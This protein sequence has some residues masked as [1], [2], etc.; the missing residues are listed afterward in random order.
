[1]IP[2]DDYEPIQ[3]QQP[4]DFRAR[5]NA[6]PAHVAAKF[7]D[8]QHLQELVEASDGQGRRLLLTASD[9]NGWQ[10]LH[11]ACRGGHRNIVRYLVMEQ[12]EHIDVH[13]TTNG[14]ATPLSLS[15]EYHGQNHPV[16]RL[17]QQI[18]ESENDSS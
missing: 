10:P 4:F 1:M 17:L 9:R 13:A 11:E 7:G 5:D 12:I 18:S 15:Q 6:T 2:E 8:L 16:T 14:G 3:Q